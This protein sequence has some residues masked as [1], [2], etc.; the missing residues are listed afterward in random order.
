VNIDV[1]RN[2]NLN[3]KINRNYYTRNYQKTGQFDQSGKG[4]WQHNPDNRRGVAYRDPT[5]SQRY[6]RASTA[7][8]VQSR[9]AYRGRTEQGGRDI[10]RD[11]AEQGKQDIGRDRAN[12]VENLQRAADERSSANQRQAQARSDASNYNAN[13]GAALNGIESGAAAR[14][15]SNRGQM[16][17][18]A[19]P[20]QQPQ[21]REAPVQPQAPMRMPMRG[22]GRRR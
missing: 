10:S 19:M 17:R 6:N 7:D 13:R 8:S 20:A 5:T 12:A 14:N 4:T 16:S 15:A 1:G 2:L 21:M 22:G 3:Q 11:R 18:Q 9:E